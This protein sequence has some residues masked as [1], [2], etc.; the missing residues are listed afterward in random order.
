MKSIIESKSD[1]NIKI[2]KET[3]HKFYSN[4]ENNFIFLPDGKTIVGPDASESQNLMKEDISIN[5][6]TLIA[7]YWDTINTILY[8]PKTKNL[9][10]V[11]DTKHVVQYKKED[12]SDTFTFFKDYG[13]LN[14]GCVIS[15]AKV[16]DFAIFGGWNSHKIAAIDLNQ[17]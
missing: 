10:L 7:E 4:F 9:F 3:A 13:D 11:D 12:K 5:N 2:N 8:D 16:G 1:C 6:P 14:I 17:N 15:S